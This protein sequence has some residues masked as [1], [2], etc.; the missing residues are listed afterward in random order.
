MDF[1]QNHE[2]LYNKTNEYF[3]DKTGKE[4][5]W[6]RFAKSCKMSVKVCKTWFE[7]KRLVKASS[8]NPILVG[9]KTK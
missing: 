1:V 4:C 2:E 7:S 5:L 9:L 8:H 6:E 3:M